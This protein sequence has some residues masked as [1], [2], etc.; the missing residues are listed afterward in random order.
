MSLFTYLLLVPYIWLF[1]ICEMT[2]IDKKLA[3]VSD[4][5]LPS[6]VLAEFRSVRNS[7]PPEKLSVYKSCILVS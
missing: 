2:C 1:F 5:L 7:P 4:K 3:K 6:R